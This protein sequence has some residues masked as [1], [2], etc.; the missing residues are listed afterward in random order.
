MVSNKLSINYS[1]TKYTLFHRQRIQ[2]LFSLYI[3]NNKIE[4]VNCIEYLGVKIDDKLTWRE[5]I[6]HIEGKLSSA[7]GAIYRLRQ[8]V[9]QECLRTFYFAHAYFHLQYSILA[10]FNTSN[11]CLQRVNSIHGKLVRLMTLHGPLKDF[12][13][14]ADEMFKNMDLLKI[15]DIFELELGKF[16]HRAQSNELPENF[17]KYFTRIENM[18]S[19]NL[20]SIKN[21]TFYTKHTNTA[22]YKNWLTNSGVELWKNIAPEMKKLPFKSFSAKCKQNIIDSY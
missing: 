12:Y 7:C 5:H 9:R 14:S 16:M 22:K 10:W 17:E 15:K 2:N 6:K 21:K 1:K 18:H 4:K 13:F 3:N 19:H 8:T 11:Q 20:R